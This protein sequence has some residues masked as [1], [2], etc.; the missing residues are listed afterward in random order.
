MNLEYLFFLSQ[1]VVFLKSKANVTQF[2]SLAFK[3]LPSEQNSVRK[4][5][6][7]LF[8]VLKCKDIRHLVL[9]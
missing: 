8:L 1:S 6:T 7:S 5:F 3:V 9:S 4:L 2:F